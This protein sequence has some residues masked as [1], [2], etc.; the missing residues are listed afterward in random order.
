M[1]IATVPFSRRRGPGWA[2]FLTWVLLAAVLATPAAGRDPRPLILAHYM[3]WY[4]A[5]PQSAGWGWHWTMNFFNPDD[6]ADGRR[7]IASKLYPVIGPYDSGDPHVLEYHLLLM[8]LAGIDGVI[9]DWYGRADLWDY[10]R[11]HANTERLVDLCGRHGMKFLIC[12]EDRTVSMLVKEGK[13][14]ADARVAHAS[15][16]IRWLAKHWFSR[17]GYVRIGDRPVLLS[18]G[19]EGLTDDEWRQCLA[20]TSEPVAYFSEHK[21]RTAAVGGFDWP[22][23]KEGPVAIER[24]AKE[25]E[26]WPHR[27]PVAYPRFLDVYGEAKVRPSWGSVADA[28]GATFR[29]TLA[30]ALAMSTDVVQIA[31]WNDW[32]EGTAIEPSLEYGNRDLEAVRAVQGRDGLE[33]D[34]AG[35]DLP[36]RLLALR[37]VA[38]DAARVE[39]IDTI[40]AMLSDGEV[41]RARAEIV[42]AEKE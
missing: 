38:G 34:D 37:R 35:L 5:K 25:A 18:F 8:K 41:G 1:R 15:D 6:V 33:G 28:D 39:R 29:Q 2:G 14:A 17:D 7:R 20:D 27:I 11:I 42:R 13:I 3:P 21:R 19:H 4:E 22:L 12:Y 30:Q 16:E 31:T 36:G 40:A 10:A 26:R 23:P 24:F 32:G 9:V